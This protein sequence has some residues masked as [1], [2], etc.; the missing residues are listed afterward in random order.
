M[1]SLDRGEIA[2]EQ[3][4]YVESEKQQP[5]VKHKLLNVSA[6]RQVYLVT[7]S[8]VNLELFPTRRS[9]AEAV[10]GSLQ[11]SNT[12]VMHW[13]CSRESH[14]NG[15][16]H[17]HMALKVDCCRRWLRSKKFLKEQHSISVHVSHL[18]YNYYSAWK[19]VT[20]QDKQFL[21]NNDHPNLWNS[22][23]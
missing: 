23:S 22:K 10:V 16:F 1:E 20:K 17:Y 21:E 14:R 11:S 19:Y 6:V 7:Y 2:G 12:R 4:G 9:F 5:T 13:V 18:H 3:G 8:Q 15:G